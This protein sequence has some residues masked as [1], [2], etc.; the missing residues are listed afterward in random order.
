MG[1]SKN[2]LIGGITGGIGSSVAN[3]LNKEGHSIVGFA[4]DEEKLN[5]FN[6]QHPNIQTIQ[7]EATDPDSVKT[8]FEKASLLMGSV[9]AYIHAIGS[10]IIKPAHLT[11]TEHW[12]Q[13]LQ[14]NL[15]S[16]FFAMKEAIIAMQKQIME[17]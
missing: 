12:I 1:N 4:R 8:V 6:Q 10:I 11:S 9:D 3:L 2:I 13:T 5:D 14:L 7:A 17:L 15:S 16:A